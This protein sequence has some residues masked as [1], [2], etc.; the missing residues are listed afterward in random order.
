MTADRIALSGRIQ[1][2]MSD[3]ARVVARCARI[4]AKAQ[5]SG[6]TDW[7]DGVAL[8]LHAFYAG[9]ESIFEEIARD[10]DDA[11]PG[12]SEWHRSLLMQMAAELP[13][14]RPLIIGRTTRDCLDTYRGFRHVVRNVYT[15]NLRPA[16]LR[17]L[18]EELPACYAALAQD[19]TSF[20]TF[21][22]DR[23]SDDA[24]TPR[25]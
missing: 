24:P 10:L 18:V 16:R 9:V 5:E 4:F 6:D 12:G 14:I 8:N 1:T 19:L 17:E 25:T 11:L 3:L 15:F 20:N 7:L 23:A 13:G 22:L 21:L 2:E